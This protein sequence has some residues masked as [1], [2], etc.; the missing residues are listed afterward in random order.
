[1]FASNRVHK[2]SLNSTEFFEN[3]FAVWQQMHRD[4]AV[5]RSRLPLMGRAWLATT[6]DATSDLLKDQDRFARDVRRAGRNAQLPFF[7][8]WFLPRRFKSLAENNILTS[9]HEDH[10]RLR[11]LV[12]EAFRRTEVETLTPR[13][14]EVSQNFIDD[15]AV[16]AKTS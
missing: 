14:E 3:P 9:D 7:V 15:F 10:R 8:N 2:S 16:E 13:I 11:F 4:G 12:D 5:V 6:W 1:M